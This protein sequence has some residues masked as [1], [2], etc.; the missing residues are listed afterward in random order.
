M[1]GGGTY[2]DT[3]ESVVKQTGGRIVP[4]ELAS[5]GDC[6]I[7]AAYLWQYFSEASN[8]RVY[9]SF[10]GLPQRISM[11]EWQAWSM[12]TRTPLA[13]FEVRI[14]TSLDSLYVSQKRGSQ[15]PKGKK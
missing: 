9:D 14:L 7:R 8:L 5:H 2:L 15:K 3:L 4:P 12:L 1:P 11:L 6:P 13:E 10:A